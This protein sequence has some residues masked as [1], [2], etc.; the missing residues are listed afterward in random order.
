M[1]ARWHFRRPWKPHKQLICPSSPLGSPLH[2][3]QAQSFPLILPGPQSLQTQRCP[4]HTCGGQLGR[5]PGLPQRP[6]GG[7]GSTGLS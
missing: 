3:S 5:G 7:S 2:G 6:A 4:L 1:M